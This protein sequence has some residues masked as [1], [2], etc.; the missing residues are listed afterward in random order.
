LYPTILEFAQGQQQ[1]T[2]IQN[3]L[4]VRATGKADR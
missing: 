1:S 2:G 3:Q 4:R